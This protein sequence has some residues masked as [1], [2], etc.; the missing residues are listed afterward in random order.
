MVAA[1]VDFIAGTTDTLVLV[2][3]APIPARTTVAAMP[4]GEALTVPVDDGLLQLER[5]LAELDSPVT[6]APSANSAES[7]PA[8]GEPLPQLRPSAGDTMP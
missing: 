3:E 8:D 1:L 6:A 4:A 7:A 2:E 5:L